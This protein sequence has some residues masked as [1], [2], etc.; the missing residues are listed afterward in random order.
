[1]PGIF[2]S[3]GYD[4]SLISVLNR[5]DRSFVKFS[6]HHALPLRGSEGTFYGCARTSA[7][8]QRN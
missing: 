2:D 8:R 3:A 1:M 7:L 5:A 4:Q 6:L